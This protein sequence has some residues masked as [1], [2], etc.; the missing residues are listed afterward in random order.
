MANSTS[1][2]K[3]CLTCAFPVEREHDVFAVLSRVSAM[4]GHMGYSVK[5]LAINPQTEPQNSFTLSFSF[6]P[7]QPPKH[8]PKRPRHQTSQP[9]RPSKRQAHQP[10]TLPT[11]QPGPGCRVC[12]SSCCSTN[13]LCKANMCHHHQHEEVSNPSPTPH[14]HQHQHQHHHHSHHQPNQPLQRQHSNQQHPATTSLQRNHPIP[15]NQTIQH[16]AAVADPD[17]NVHIPSVTI[18]ERES[19]LSAP[20]DITQPPQQSIPA[21][22]RNSVEHSRAIIQLAEVPIPQMTSKDLK[23]GWTATTAANRHAPVTSFDPEIQSRGRSSKKRNEV[24]PRPPP[25]LLCTLCDM[26]FEDELS[27]RRH[28]FTD[29]KETIQ[30]TKTAE[31][32]FLCLMH[33]C[34][35]TFVRR[36]VMERHFKTVH[37]LVRDFPCPTCSKTFADSST[38]EAHRT[39]V[40]EKKRP[41]VCDQCSS[42]FTQSSSLGKHKRRFHND[43]TGRPS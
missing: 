34:T 32:R 9:E 6:Y 5:S 26:R 13:S 10:S 27:F 15:P 3:Q 29:H 2:Q 7:S 40:H 30:V 1:S 39:A 12:A 18:P 42:S 4:M 33:S 28:Q 8:S 37:L 25:D 21:T 41:W 11:S 31:G 23:D 14:E 36:H 24:N 35:Q 22:V 38:R 43:S 19:V 16:R 17:P 20:D